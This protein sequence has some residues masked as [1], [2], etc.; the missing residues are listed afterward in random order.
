MLPVGLHTLH[1]L[2]IIGE[3]AQEHTILSF[4]DKTISYGGRDLLKRM[5]REPKECVGDIL[6]QQELLRSVIANYSYWEVNVS[7]AYIAATEH[8][9]ES[10]IGHT[11]SQDIV[12]HW[13]QT[14]LFAYK[15]EAEFYLIQSG[16]TATIRVFR[17]MK[18]TVWLLSYMDVPDSFK[19][20]FE[21]IVSFLDSLM[22]RPYM[23][24][25]DRGINKISVF[26][27]DYFLRKQRKDD[28]R[29]MLDVLYKLDALVSVATVAR[30]H[31]LCFPE[32]AS[33]DGVLEVAGLWHP[34]LQNPV[35]NGCVLAGETGICILTGANTSGK[36][37]FLKA[38][39]I[40][41]YLAHLGWPVPAAN[42][43]LSFSDRLFTSIHL[44]D[45]LTL[46][47]SH[48]YNEIMRIKEIAQALGDGQKCL[49]LI[50]EL[51]RGT[52]QEDALH[53]SGTVVNGFLNYPS[54]VFVISTHLMELLKSYDT[55]PYIRFNCFK[56]NIT[57]NGFENTYK[58][59][60]GIATEKV[61]KLI[62][63]NVGIPALL[64]KADNNKALT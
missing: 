59:E 41:V 40:S 56:T 34:L 23:Q 32:F 33:I 43:R 10:N 28:F 8:Y 9:Y 55:N 7:H 51:F 17:A 35:K 54:S 1:E 39:G 13:L 58:L 44:S 38:L 26:H 49:V 61:G 21:F 30:D 62:M 53:C 25:E 48:F 36:T 27:L 37:T 18:K 60:A 3:K 4:F 42:L 19:K 20:D 29:K 50:D 45:D 52:N 63:D 12:Q 31:S 22:L 11:M 15:N 6:Q 64:A 47:Y 14:M 5:I 24:E 46:G 2:Q 57:T 16:V